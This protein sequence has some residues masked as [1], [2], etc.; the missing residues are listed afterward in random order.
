MSLEGAPAIAKQLAFEMNIPCGSYLVDAVETWLQ[1]AR[2]EREMLQRATGVFGSNLEWH[3]LQPP[4]K[5]H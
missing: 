2:D 4:R 3:L 5:A 1:G